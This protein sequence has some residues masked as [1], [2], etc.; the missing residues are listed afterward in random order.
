MGPRRLVRLSIGLGIMLLVYTAVQMLF[1]NASEQGQTEEEVSHP[2]PVTEDWPSVAIDGLVPE[3]LR[4]WADYI[5]TKQTIWNDD[6]P[7]PSGAD[8]R[9]VVV[10]QVSA[11]PEK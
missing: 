11:P 3:Q 8:E 9:F 7:T 1:W 5:N 10:V 2:P 4:T 6:L